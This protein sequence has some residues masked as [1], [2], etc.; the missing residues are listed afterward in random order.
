MQDFQQDIVTPAKAGVHATPEMV[1][2]V[3]L[4]AGAGM[5]VISLN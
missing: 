5:T 1:P 3:W 4:P 2:R